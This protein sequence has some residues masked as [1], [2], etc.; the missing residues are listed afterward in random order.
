M[1]STLA[2]LRCTGLVLALLFAPLV[3]A[4]A[5]RASDGALE[6][7]Q[8]C[9]IQTGCF[10]GDTAGFPV[11]ITP[12]A[13][14]HS[15]RLTSDLVNSDTATDVISVA[16]SG[17]DIDLGGFEIASRACVG[18]TSKCTPAAGPGS[19]VQRTSALVGFSLR[20]GTVTGMSRHGVSAGID[21]RIEDV[22]ARWNAGFG[23]TALSGSH[24]LRCQAIEN[25]AAGIAGD[26]ASVVSDNA[27]IGNGSY[28]IT[29][30]AGSV[31]SN[32]ALRSNKGAGIS[33]T[34]GTLV[35][36]NS[37]A[38]NSGVGLELFATTLYRGNAIVSNSG[39]P[40]TGGFNGG[41]NF[42]SGAGT[43]SATCP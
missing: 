4:P 23:I 5:A 25:G 33:A 12:A 42:C 7:N 27:S 9:A 18:A 16:L 3:A 26:T 22:R 37:V 32:N 38:Q 24:I 8:T 29:V 15:F 6:I 1:R 41:G 39:G 17:A 31:V 36:G 13:N 34:I 30:S 40:V 35:S 11:T 19:G 28:G 43:G 10:P 21:S 14:A 20:N 2:A